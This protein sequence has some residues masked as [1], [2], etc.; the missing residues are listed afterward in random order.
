[1]KLTTKL[2]RQLIKETIEEGLQEGTHTYDDWRSRKRSE[3]EYELGDEDR[4]T[5]INKAFKGIKIRDVEDDDYEYPTSEPAP[6]PA[7]EKPSFFS[8]WIQTDIPIGYKDSEGRD[9]KQAKSYHK[10]Q[11]YKVGPDRA[12]GEINA[13][14]AA[15]E[16]AQDAVARKFASKVKDAML[17]MY[18]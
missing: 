2:L 6:A 17:D 8:T 3:L 12:F 15:A 18:G 9:L 11:I 1:M 7:K 10:G 13:M 16:K 14:A 5:P 4:G